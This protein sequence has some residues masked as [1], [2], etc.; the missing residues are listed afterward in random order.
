MRCYNLKRVLAFNYLMCINSNFENKIYVFPNNL[1]PYIMNNLKM[2]RVNFV[3]FHAMQN[4][5]QR[6]D[7]ELMRLRGIH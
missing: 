4:G 7:V 5:N 6:I 2:E 3:Q 1:N